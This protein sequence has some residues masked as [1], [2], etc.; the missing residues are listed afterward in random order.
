MATAP[1]SSRVIS[2]RL[3]T[4][5][6]RWLASPWMERTRSRR[7]AES[8]RSAPS[9]R[10]LEAPMMVESGVRKS[11]ETELRSEFRIRSVS[12]R[13]SARR[14]SSASCARSMAR[15]VWL[16]KVSSWWRASGLSKACPSAGTIAST[17]T[18]P[19]GPASGTHSARA[20]GRVAVPRPATS[21]CSNAHCATPA[22]VTPNAMPSGAT[23]RG[24][25]CPLASGSNRAIWPE[26]TSPMWR[27]AISRRPSTPGMLASSRLMPYSAAIRR[28]RWRA[29]TTWARMRTVSPLVTSATTSITKKV[30]RCSVSDTANE[31]RAARRRSRRRRR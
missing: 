23:R 5:R 10:P 28:S 11:W 27:K 31:G 29:A 24:A 25:R 8:S 21:R 1:A 12:A 9:R 18:A 14:A 4:S 17:P 6:S 7:V 26:K 19:R 2:S 15:A 30:R 13:T 22:S 16:A 3:F 20:P